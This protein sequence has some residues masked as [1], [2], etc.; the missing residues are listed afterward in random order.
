M[1][2]LIVCDWYEECWIRS[3]ATTAPIELPL[4]RPLSNSHTIFF[5]QL[6]MDKWYRRIGRTSLEVIERI[7]KSQGTPIWT[8]WVTVECHSCLVVVSIV[9]FIACCV[10]LVESTV[11]EESC[12]LQKTDV[13]F[14]WRLTLHACLECLVGPHISTW[15]IIGVE[16][17]IGWKK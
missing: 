17:V 15:V 2:N 10:F 4:R 9:S 11:V 3:W 1:K 6:I 5:V 14:I 16:F 12:L 8:I 7:L 13:S